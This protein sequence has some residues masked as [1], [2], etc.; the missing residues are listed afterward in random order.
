MSASEPSW[1]LY[2]ALLAV[3]REG[4]LSGA[5][6]ALGLTQPTVR[7]QIEQLE[8]DL[9]VVLFTRSAN[10]LVPT[11][12]ARAAMPYAE[13]I[14]S[15]ARALARAVSAGH[16]AA[17]GTVRVTCSE[18]VGVEVLPPMLAALRR[19]KP[20]LQVEVV[21]TNRT[22]DLLRRDADV[23]VRMV[24]PTQAG[25]VRKRAGRIE[26]GLFADARYLAR[27]PPPATLAALTDGHWLVGP[28]RGRGLV[29]GLAAY[30]VHVTAKHFGTRS[31][32]DVVQLAAVRAGL[33]IGVCQVPLARG[34]RPLVRVVPELALHLDAWIVMHEDLRA[35]ARVRSVFDHLVE[36]FQR[37]AAK[38]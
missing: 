27:H 6:R 16:D 25:L 24:E 11:E 3:L 8:H 5:A 19:T 38:R 36:A 35:S 31:D 10:G 18:I 32:S 7:R 12:L 1:D 21:A 17:R 4:S 26:L 37:Y 29:D 20:D 2:G 22:E 14:S 33:G 9:G 34:P 13:S 15:T 30:G 23:A 28:D